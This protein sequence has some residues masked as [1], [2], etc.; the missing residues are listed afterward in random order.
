ME[1]GESIDEREKQV[2]NILLNPDSTAQEVI[3]LYEAW[4]ETY[5]QVIKW[6]LTEFYD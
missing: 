1:L 6:H 3:Q 4:N 2:D 5:D